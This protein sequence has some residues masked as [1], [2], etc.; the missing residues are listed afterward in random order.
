M[1]CGADGVSAGETQCR[2]FRIEVLVTLQ[3]RRARP[4]Q[5]RPRPACGQVGHDLLHHT[6]GRGL[7]ER[8]VEVASRQAAEE[9]RSQIWTDK[10]K[11]LREG[12]PSGGG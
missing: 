7:R 2:G 5:E 12:L 1:A 4:V 8:E 6:Q 10:S 11:K 3:G 9:R